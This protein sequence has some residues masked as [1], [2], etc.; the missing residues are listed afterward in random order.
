MLSY[1]TVTMIVAVRLR[2]NAFAMQGVPLGNP[3]RG[4][5]ANYTQL[6]VG[7]AIR[8]AGCVN[9][10]VE[11]C[12]LYTTWAVFETGGKQASGQSAVA[13]SGGIIQNNV[14]W[15]GGGLHNFDTAREITMENNTCTGISLGS[16]GSNIANYNFWSG[17]TQHIYFGSNSISHVWGSDREVMTFDPCAGAYVANVSSAVGTSLRFNQ[18]TQV[19]DEHLQGA[20]VGGVVTV[21]AGRGAGQIRRLVATNFNGTVELDKPFL[22]SLDPTSFVQLSDMRGQMIFEGNHYSDVGAFQLCEKMFSRKTDLD[23]P[24]Q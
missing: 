24:V 17:Y 21:L 6:E 3:S 14:I 7:A 19:T 13:S 1:L 20:V 9:F 16:F 15:F 23:L 11:Q 4:R 5:V 10:V 2:A 22:T 8:F 12:D 18:S